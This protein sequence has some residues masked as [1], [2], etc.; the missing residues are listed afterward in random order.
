MNEKLELLGIMIPTE[1]KKF[2]KEIAS[3]NRLTMSDVAR[4]LISDSIEHIA[5]RDILKL[6]V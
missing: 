3:R 5:E 6:I 4:M 1:D 2:I